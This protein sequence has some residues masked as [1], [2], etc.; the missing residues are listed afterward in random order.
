MLESLTVK[1]S[2]AL[3]SSS[4]DPR[5]S[6]LSGVPSSYGRDGLYVMHLDRATVNLPAS[7]LPMDP[8]ELL[9]YISF[10]KLN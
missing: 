5:S 6:V 4:S 8:A 10:V 3:I 1:L 9:D 7:P 2:E